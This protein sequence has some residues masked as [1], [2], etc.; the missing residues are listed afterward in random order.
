MDD[1]EQRL[2]RMCN[3]LECENYA[4]LARSLDIT[5]QEVYRWRKKGM[6]RSMSAALDALLDRLERKV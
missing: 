6:T 3:A 2:Q 4:D 1:V 5:H